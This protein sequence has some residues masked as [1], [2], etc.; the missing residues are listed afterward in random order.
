M[1]IRLIGLA[2]TGLAAA[3]VL[4]RRGERV[5][6][7]DEKPAERLG[8]RPTELAALGVEC[9]L[10]KDAYQGVESADLVVPSPGVPAGAPVLREAVERG[11][12]V[13]AEI[14]L[15]WEIARAPILAVTGT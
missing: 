1:E 10:G 12:P 8:D 5:I 7:H 4:R 13:R 9:R 3:R 14:E 6:A 11:T 2:A 15:A